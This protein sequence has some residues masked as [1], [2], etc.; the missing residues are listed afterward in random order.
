MTKQEIN[1][2]AKQFVELQN[3]LNVIRTPQYYF[4]AGATM[5]N[6][7]QPYTKDDIENAFREGQKSGAN[8]AK[9]MKHEIPRKY[10]ELIEKGG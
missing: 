10:I 7:I 9:R 8:A 5:V 3:A 2:E 4:R 6:E 1:Q